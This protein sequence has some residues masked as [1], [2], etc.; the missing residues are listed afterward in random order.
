MQTSFS[1]NSERALVIPSVSTATAQTPSASSRIPAARRAH[2]AMTRW[3]R[4]M[5][6]FCGHSSAMG[7]T[8]S[9]QSFRGGSSFWLGNHMLASTSQHSLRRS[10]RVGWDMHQGPHQGRGSHP[11]QRYPS[12]PWCVAYLRLGHRRDRGCGARR[13]TS[14]PAYVHRPPQRIRPQWRCRS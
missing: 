10:F 14:W 4:T 1:W 6:P 3:Q 5:W 7:T 11:P 8:P 9:S 2:P 13:P 12:M